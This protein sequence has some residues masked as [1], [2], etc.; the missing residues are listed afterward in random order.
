ML[1]VRVFTHTVSSMSSKNRL[2]DNWL[3]QQES[4]LDAYIER[5]FEQN[6]IDDWYNAAHWY[7]DAIVSLFGP[8]GHRV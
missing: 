5:V 4:M 7:V 1:F 8:K 3:E 2:S 6:N